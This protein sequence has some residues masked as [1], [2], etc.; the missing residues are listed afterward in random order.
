MYQK[1]TKSIKL[2][3]KNLWAG[4]PGQFAEGSNSA[5]AR[6]VEDYN[7]MLDKHIFEG[8]KISSEK[9]EAEAKAQLQR[10]FVNIIT[11]LGEKWGEEIEF[12]A[13][14]IDVEP[15]EPVIETADLED[16]DESAEEDDLFF[17]D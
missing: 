8:D 2:P 5:V 17:D 12:P 3:F 10:D 16:D 9:F 15:E 4:L 7:A 13:E 6:I 1:A 11:H 14:K